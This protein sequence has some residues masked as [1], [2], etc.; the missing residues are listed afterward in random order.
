MLLYFNSLCTLFET[1][2]YVTYASSKVTYELRGISEEDSSTY[3]VGHH[4]I[5]N[6]L[7]KI[8]I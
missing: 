7:K 3:L 6:K 1:M 2:K 5:F 8:M 4:F